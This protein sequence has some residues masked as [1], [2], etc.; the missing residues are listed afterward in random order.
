ML[1]AAGVGAVVV[2]GVVAVATSIVSRVAF[3]P[4]K[5]VLAYLAA[6]EEGRAADALE[7][8]GITL[9]DGDG[10]LLTDEVY[11]E[12]ADRPTAS[13]VTSVV[14]RGKSAAV[15]VRS[16]QAGGSVSET[17]QVRSDGRRMLFFD[18]WVLHD[19]PIPELSVLSAL[20]HEADAFL[21]DG[22]AHSADDGRVLVLP[23]TYTVELAPPEGAEGLI[24]SDAI[25][26]TVDAGSW[27]E[28]VSHRHVLSYELTAEGVA[29]AES[30]TADFLESTCLSGTERALEDC[31]FTTWPLRA[32][33]AENT[34]WAF[35]GTPTVE[36]GLD[37]GAITAEISGT[38]RATYEVAE[39]A[40]RAGGTAE[41][42]DDFGFWLRFPAQDGALGAPEPSRYG[43]WD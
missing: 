30:A 15:S 41:R 17:F 8:A 35:S 26:V 5:P 6:I 14:R 28:S 31:G 1:L 11:A 27:Y 38:T 36:V 10:L 24:T 12:V 39:T 33:E 18:R 20:P 32:D 34:R 22:V 7:L 9:R 4:E 13:R 16:E 29:A 19:H 3:S 37:R 2:V 23:G 42:V 25:E 43:Y 40:Y 21:V